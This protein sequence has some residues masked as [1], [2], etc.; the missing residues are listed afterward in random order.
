MPTK[1]II[2]KGFRVFFE[3]HL[4]HQFWGVTEQV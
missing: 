3:R 4:P 1:G 2:R